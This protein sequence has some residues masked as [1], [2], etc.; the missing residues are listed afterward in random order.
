M[1]INYSKV[2]SAASKKKN[3]RFLWTKKMLSERENFLYVIFT[4][5]CSVSYWSRVSGDTGG[6]VKQKS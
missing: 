4:D 3:K 5:E 1:D 6:K 2:L